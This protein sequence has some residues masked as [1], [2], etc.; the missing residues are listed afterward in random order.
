MHSNR[1]SAGRAAAV[2]L[3][4]LTSAAC[5]DPGSRS[6]ATAAGP[7]ASPEVET[8]L[9][10]Y[11]TVPLTSDLEV[12]APHERQMLQ[13]FIE[14]V[15]PM[16]D[17]FW[18]EAYGDPTALL[19]GAPDERT[20]RALR[21]NFGPWD[22]LDGNA[23][24]LPG[25]GEK[26]AGANFYPTDMTREEFEAAAAAAPDGGAALRSLYTLVRRSA[27]G[28]LEAIPYHVAFREEHERAA[29]HLR[30]A[31]ALAR[32]PG[33]RAYLESRAAALLSDDYQA[34]DLAWM[35]MRAGG[36][37]VVLGPI[38]TY[39]DQLFGYKAAHEGYVL[40]KDREWS[41]RLARYAGMLPE[42]QRG[43][44][45]PDAYKRETPGSEADLGAY[46]VVYVSGQANEGAKTI[47]FNL[48]NDEEVQLRKGTRRVQLKN[49]M[50]AK[51]D[52]ILRPIADAVIAED[53]RPLVTFDAFFDNTMFHEVAHGLGVK[54]TI[55]GRSTVREALQEHY[56]PLEEGKADILGLYFVTR[57]YDAGEAM[58][59]TLEEHY[60]TF[61]AS[62]FRSIRFGA[63][64][65][66]GR[67]NMVR[68]SFFRDRGA[69]TR[70]PV[71]GT[72]RVDVDRMRVAMDALTETILRIQGDGDHAR[73]GELLSSLGVIDAQVQEDLDRLAELDVPVDLLFEQ[74]WDVLTR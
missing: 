65:A 50:R 36:V 61:M 25:V 2:S 58:A 7:G 3:I 66:H 23:P 55:D 20:R 12:L 27:A 71:T 5:T 13:L 15:E 60:V 70:D 10:R 51:F 64:S 73:A 49:V 31:A 30:A 44:P 57:L 47:A 6:A 4:L 35:D 1:T 72:Y 32:E 28:E 53:Q 18:V 48:P 45:V 62:I 59:G 40:V 19:A 38:E 9:A 26:P 37:D 42:M 24:F 39:E 69:F 8:V 43:I 14:A 46:D 63:A 11:V 54:S 34:S 33:L 29:E 67:A 16:D 68:F 17:A 56:S 52:Q 21:A 22:R 74:G 41:G